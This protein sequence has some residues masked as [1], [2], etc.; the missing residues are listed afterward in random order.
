MNWDPDEHPI[1]VLG[2][3]FDANSL[4]RWIYDWTVYRYGHDTSA[5]DAAGS[6]WPAL[7]KLAGIRRNAEQ[8]L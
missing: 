8:L 5:L 6:L 1:V 4:G 3:V 7:I 2:M